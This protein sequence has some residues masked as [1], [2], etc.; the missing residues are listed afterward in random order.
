MSQCV[1][2]SNN[3]GKLREFQSILQPLNIELIPL[4]QITNE[5]ANE[6]GLSFIENAILKARHA[7]QQSGL[8]A[9][10][11]DSGLVI[12]ALAGEPGIFSARYSGESAS[13][14]QNIDLVLQK[15]AGIKNRQAYFFC[16]LVYMQH[17]ADPC[18]LIATGQFHGEITTARSGAGGFGYD[19]IFFLTEKNCTAA[20]LPAEVKNTISHRAIASQALLSMMTSQLKDK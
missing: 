5:Q 8:A 2:A 18:P 9:I 4:A 6:T 10:A 16:A 14:A 20:Q 19:P 12:P 15:M 13:D 7:C 1:V 3:Q 17:A 11:D